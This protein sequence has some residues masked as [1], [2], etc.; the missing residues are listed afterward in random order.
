[1]YVSKLKQGEASLGG[2]HTTDSRWSIYFEN[3]AFWSSSYEY[4]GD[5]PEKVVE[6]VTEEKVRE[7]ILFYNFTGL[8]KTKES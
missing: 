1:L 8:Q 5:Y 6:P 3:N 7:M 4:R 2:G